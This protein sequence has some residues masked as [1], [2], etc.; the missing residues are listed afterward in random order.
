MEA[1]NAKKAQIKETEAHNKEKKT[2]PKIID[3]S[4]SYFSLY[5]SGKKEM[6]PGYNHNFP[7]CSG[8]HRI[9]KSARKNKIQN[10]FISS[11]LA[12]L[13]SAPSLFGTEMFFFRRGHMLEDLGFDCRKSLQRKNNNFENSM[14]NNAKNMA[15]TTHKQNPNQYQRAFRMGK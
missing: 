14:P 7:I 15:A 9:H 4:K 13:H 5:D 8:T 11:F 2:M 12:G 3:C 6:Y 10:R 1:S